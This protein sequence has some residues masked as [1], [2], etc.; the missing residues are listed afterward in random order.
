MLRD[1]PVGVDRGCLSFNQMLSAGGTMVTAKVPATKYAKLNSL[2]S[3]VISLNGRD[4]HRACRHTTS[5]NL[6][7]DFEWRPAM[8]PYIR[9]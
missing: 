6:P 7:F 3:F 9:R 1:V 5:L 8:R 2:T 4:L